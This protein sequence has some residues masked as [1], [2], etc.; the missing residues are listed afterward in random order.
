MVATDAGLSGVGNRKLLIRVQQMRPRGA[1]A[2]LALDIHHVRGQFRAEEP[3]QTL[4]FFELRV[5]ILWRLPGFKPN[6]MAFQAFRV[7]VFAFLFQS[8]KRMS[9]AAFFPDFRCF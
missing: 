2:V 9:V 7:E 1:V 6:H 5:R 8:G 3:D 4:P